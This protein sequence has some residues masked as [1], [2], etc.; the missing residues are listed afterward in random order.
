MA[1]GVESL[2]VAMAAQSF[3]HQPVAELLVGDVLFELDP[4][5]LDIFGATVVAIR[6][7]VMRRLLR[8]LEIRF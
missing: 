5:L 1:R 3:S 4:Q 7:S 6:S 8:R 2:N